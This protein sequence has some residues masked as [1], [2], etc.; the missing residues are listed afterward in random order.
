MAAK[1][2]TSR[3]MKTLIVVACDCEIYAGLRVCMLYNIDSE[4]KVQKAT[5]LHPSL[6]SFPLLFHLTSF[7]PLAESPVSL[8]QSHNTRTRTQACTS[9]LNPSPHTPF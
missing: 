9:I 3:N 5:S 4:D 7:V 1:N 6:S 2:N 8:I